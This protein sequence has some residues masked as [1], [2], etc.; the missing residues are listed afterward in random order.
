M[1]MYPGGEFA[2][3]VSRGIELYGLPKA[4][5]YLDSILNSCHVVD[6]K[7]PVATQP[8]QH[9]MKLKTGLVMVVKIAA[10]LMEALENC[11][12]DKDVCE[13]YSKIITGIT[14]IMMFI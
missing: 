11:K 13:G 10:H 5:E 9:I 1:Q 14:A 4:K 8:I 7:T 2:S 6:Q 3:L 12:A